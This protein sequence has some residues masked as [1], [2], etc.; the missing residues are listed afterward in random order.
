MHLVFA[1]GANKFLLRNYGKRGCESKTFVKRSSVKF[2]LGEVCPA[3]TLICFCFLWSNY[4]L[5]LPDR[6]LYL[7][8]VSERCCLVDSYCSLRN[9]GQERTSLF[10]KF[11]SMLL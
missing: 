4:C 1:P 11:I 10:I 5:V 9:V 8:A 7:R 3:M 2:I 6:W